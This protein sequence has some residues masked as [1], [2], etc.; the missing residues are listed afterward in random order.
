[1][2][3][4]TLRDYNIV[5]TFANL[6][7]CLSRVFPHRLKWVTSTF[8]SPLNSFTLH[9]HTHTRCFFSHLF[10]YIGNVNAVMFFTTR[11]SF[12][13]T[14]ADVVTHIKQ[15]R[16]PVSA[17]LCESGHRRGRYSETGLS[18]YRKVRPV[19]PWCPSFSLCSRKFPTLFTKILHFVPGRQQRQLL[20]DSNK[21]R[22]LE[23]IVSFDTRDGPDLAT[24]NRG[25]CWTVPDSR[26]GRVFHFS[27]R[28]VLIQIAAWLGGTNKL[29][30]KDKK[31]SE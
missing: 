26:A 16:T 12:P 6:H 18:Q 9:T 30:C 29:Y 7:S 4:E 1:M 17:R 2:W 20:H 13:L 14:G 23:K 5:I 8:T 25:W 22:K 10:L 24:H 21:R 3:I 31:S 15:T 28:S 27:D 19:A 11:S